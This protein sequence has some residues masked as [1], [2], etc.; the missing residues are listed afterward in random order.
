MEEQII[1]ALLKTVVANVYP[2]EAIEEA[3]YPHIVYSRQETER[4]KTLCGS[5]P[6]RA[7]IY[8]DIWA[9]SYT[10]LKTIMGQLE[11]FDCFSGSVPGSSTSSSEELTVQLIELESSADEVDPEELLYH[12]LQIFS[13]YL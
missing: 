1:H 9:T 7:E 2:L 6:Y 8:V 10:E 3:P 13:V 12:G 5:E 4:L 11:A